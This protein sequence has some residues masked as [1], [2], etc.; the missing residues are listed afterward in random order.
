ME[1]NKRLDIELMRI[2]AV[3]FVIFNH[4]G[5]TGFFFFSL[6]MCI[7]CS[8]GYIFSY[9]YFANYRFHCFL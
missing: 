3:F 8:I 5:K 9:P 7:A 2:I 1:K 4:T 6:M